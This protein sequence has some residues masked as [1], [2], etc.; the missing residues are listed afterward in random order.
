M[1]ALEPW[2]FNVYLSMLILCLLDITRALLTLGTTP[3]TIQNVYVVHEAGLSKEI[4][5]ASVQF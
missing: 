2:M 4:E 3:K 1:S 5:R